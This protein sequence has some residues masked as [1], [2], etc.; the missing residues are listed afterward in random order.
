MMQH[1]ARTDTMKAF[2][3]VDIVATSGQQYR[4]WVLRTGSG[5]YSVYCPEAEHQV[6]RGRTLES[7]IRG[8]GFGR[9]Y[10]FGGAAFLP[11]N[12]PKR[13]MAAPQCLQGG[14]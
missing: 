10:I 7:A 13:A 12:P 5:G 2:S 11:L 1:I 14:R 6:A 4:V 3:T 9:K 8:L